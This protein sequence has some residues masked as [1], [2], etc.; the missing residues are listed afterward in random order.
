MDRA[1]ARTL[2]RYILAA[3]LVVA[4]LPRVLDL[5]GV[6][7][8]GRYQPA[9]GEGGTQLVIDTQT[10]RAWSRIVRTNQGTV[11]WQQDEPVQDFPRQQ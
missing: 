1:A 4:L 2:G 7:G 11:H 10:G 3:A 9:T 8:P 5:A 6:P